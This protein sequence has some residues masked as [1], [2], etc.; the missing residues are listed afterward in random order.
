MNRPSI[1]IR[2]GFILS[3]YQV[4]PDSPKELLIPL[5]KFI[6]TPKDYQTR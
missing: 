1:K 5:E 4:R 3:V 2:N 6:D